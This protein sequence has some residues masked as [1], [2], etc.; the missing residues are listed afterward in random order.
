MH[1]K[2]PYLA[3]FSVSFLF[4]FLGSDSG[5]YNIVQSTKTSGFESMLCTHSHDRLRMQK[6]K[7]LASYPNLKSG[8]K[9]EIY[10]L[11]QHGVHVGLTHNLPLNFINR[12]RIIFC[13]CVRV[14]SS[15]CWAQPSLVILYAVPA[16][17]ANLFQYAYN[18]LRTCNHRIAS[19]DA[20]K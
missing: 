14:R 3:H 17:P 19:S 16:K 18:T 4:L 10:Q 11:L 6:K 1:T 2:S 13:R 12:Q 5:G 9:N 15:T 20:R 8:T 7:I